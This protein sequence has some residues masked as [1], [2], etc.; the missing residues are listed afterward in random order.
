MIFELL[1]LMLL[2]LMLKNR[3]ETLFINF[4]RII[5]RIKKNYNKNSKYHN[6]LF[7]SPIDSIVFFF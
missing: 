1:M 2:V 3:E 7:S 6:G 5:I 4:I